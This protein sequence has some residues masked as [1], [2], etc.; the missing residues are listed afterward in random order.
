MRLTGSGTLSEL[1]QET[2][3]L[4]RITL[5]HSLQEEQKARARNLKR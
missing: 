1:Y 4:D 3:K 5:L 2:S